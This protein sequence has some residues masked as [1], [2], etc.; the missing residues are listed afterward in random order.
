[1]AWLGVNYL[2]VITLN[3]VDSR[4]DKRRHHPLDLAFRECIQTGIIRIVHIV[5]DGINTWRRAFVVAFH[6]A[7]AGVPALDIQ[8]VSRRAHGSKDM[9]ITSSHPNAALPS[10]GVSRIKSP[11]P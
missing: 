4:V 1:M 10:A 5:V 7:F 2:A 3:V 8:H 9:I 11:F 6:C